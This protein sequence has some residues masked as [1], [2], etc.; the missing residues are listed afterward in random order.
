MNV[1]YAG[2]MPGT[3]KKHWQN[4]DNAKFEYAGLMPDKK[5]EKFEFH[6]Y[7]KMIFLYAGLLPGTFVKH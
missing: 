5:Y 1:L 7:M 4:C 2:L 6:V 3:F